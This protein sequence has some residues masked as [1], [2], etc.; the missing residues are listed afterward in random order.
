VECGDQPATLQCLVCDDPFCSLCF[1]AQHKKGKRATH[2]NKSLLPEAAP[3]AAVAASAVAA[4]AAAVAA[5]VAPPPSAAASAVPPESSTTATA[6]QQELTVSS[7]SKPSTNGHEHEHDGDHD[8]VM[9]PAVVAPPE[10][11]LRVVS[12]AQSVTSILE[13][14]KFIPVR[15][16]HEDRKMLRL[17]EAAMKVSEYT[18]KVDILASARAKRMHVQIRE[19]CAILSALVV[20][21]DYT[22]GQALIKD[23]N[24]KENSEFFQRIFELGRRHKILNPEKLRTVGRVFFLD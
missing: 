13:R 22:A 3:I 24:F 8:A 18:D 23:R 1:Q 6:A 11:P 16:S 19:T 12:D 14:S 7:N 17:L 10:R 20:A 5:A 9:S 15:L 21:T 4:P 2:A